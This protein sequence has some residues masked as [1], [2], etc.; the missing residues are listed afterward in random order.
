M[1]MAHA[2]TTEGPRR[3]AMRATPPWQSFI[4]SAEIRSFDD[5]ESAQARA[6]LEKEIVMT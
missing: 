1:K 6:S 3:E 4:Q 2:E 5:S